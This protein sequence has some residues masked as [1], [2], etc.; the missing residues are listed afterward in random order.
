MDLLPNAA[1]AQLA[2]TIR[3]IGR[4]GFAAAL[5]EWLRR[6]LATDNFLVLGWAEAGPPAA[7]YAR[8]DA[9]A[10]FAHLGSYLA[11]A[12]LLDP[13]HEL[14]LRRVPRGVYRLSDVAPDAFRRSRYFRD[15]YRRTTIIDE[16]TVIAY[17]VSG[18]VLNL[19]L[20]RDATSARR[21]AAREIEMATRLAPVIAALGESHWADLAAGPRPEGD[22]PGALRAALAA[23]GVG[24]SP[25]QAEVALLILRGHSSG[26]IALR[27][28]VSAATVKVFRRQ[29]YGRCG[30]SSQ[31]ELFAL[32]MPL[33]EAG[34][35]GLA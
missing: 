29:L 25:R 20:G 12:Y 21:F 4:P 22:L 13:F 28:G 31:A 17:P 14:N 7:L 9:P 33:V 1:E 2:E 24:V 27:L 16:L 18:G 34:A 19:C 26:S 5:H 8:A 23:R 32:L 30:I 10:A 11:G 35:L 15:Y 6:C 3:L